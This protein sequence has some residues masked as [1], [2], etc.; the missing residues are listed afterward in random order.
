MD[1]TFLTPMAA[2]FAVSALLPVG[3]YWLRERR[4]NRIRNVLGLEEPSL[5]SRVPLV[6]AVAAVP[7][8]LGIA[9]AQPVL[10]TERSVPERTDAEAFF[11]M[12]TSRSMLAADG[13]EGATRFDRS[14][15]AASTIR[16]RIPQVRS[17]IVS[18]TDRLL[19][20]VLPTT[21]RRVFE[22]T[23][24][25][26]IGVELPP[27]AFTYST[28]ATAYDILAGIP[29]RRYFSQAA[30][31]RVLVVLT[32]GESRPFGSQLQGA[33]P[34]KP[35]IQTVFVRFGNTDERIYSTG[36]AEG[37]VPAKNSEET[38]ARVA[39]LM[40]GQAFSEDDVA[41]AA[42]AV[43][44]LIGEGATNDRKI[45]GA[46]VAL[47]PWVTLAASLPLAFGAATAPSDEA[48][49]VAAAHARDGERRDTNGH[50]LGGDRRRV[51]HMLT[52]TNKDRLS[53][54]HLID[55]AVV[56]DVH[57][58][59]HDIRELVELR[60]LHRLHPAVLRAHAGDAEGVVARARVTGELGDLLRRVA[61]SGDDRRAR[62]HLG[63]SRL[64]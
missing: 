47:M 54:L 5:R 13:A 18:M 34:G 41:G 36:E 23:L 57:L 4:A 17:G 60:D 30:K 27:P 52:R 61:G 64:T 58:A 33:F 32:D 53:G 55:A 39:D 19:P 48:S 25:R 8:L 24:R 49:A 59:R 42:D 11:V 38:M 20:H 40:G 7:V 28:H 35:P 31:K 22:T 50:V 12:D 43:A 16:D 3:I 37:Y 1:L 14:V 21:D 46:R 26:S 56:L 44:A 45:P 29:Q 2:I 10:G 6:L 63:H 9:A 51:A 62:K 15:E